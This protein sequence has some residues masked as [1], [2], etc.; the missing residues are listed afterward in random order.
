MPWVV[1]ECQSMTYR[2]EY[3][4]GK[5]NL[6]GDA[7]SRTPVIRERPLA[8]AG[9]DILLAELLSSLDEETRSTIKTWVWAEK[10][11]ATSQVFY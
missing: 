6:L 9:M 10:E 8:V 5:I 7:M 11:T 2:V 1:E 4:P 3:Y